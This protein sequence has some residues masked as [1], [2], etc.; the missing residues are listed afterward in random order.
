MLAREKKS[1]LAF[2]KVASV[3]SSHCLAVK[4]LQYKQAEK[5]TEGIKELPPSYRRHFGRKTHIRIP[6]A[7][8]AQVIR[9]QVQNKRLGRGDKIKSGLGDLAAGA[10]AECEAAGDSTPLRLV[11][12]L[13]WFLKYY[14]S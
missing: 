12:Q 4:R 6:A 9:L 13:F 10:L 14:K 11:R 1:L 3:Q 2:P 5:K 7:H 8:P